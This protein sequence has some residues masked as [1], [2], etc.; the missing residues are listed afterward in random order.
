MKCKLLLCI[1][2]LFVCVTTIA[3]ASDYLLPKPQQMVSS[4]GF[5]SMGKVKLDASVL[6]SEW[7]RFVQECGGEVVD[8]S[9]KS[10]SVRMVPSVVGAKMNQ[11]E[12]YRLVVSSKGILVEATTEKGVYWALQTLRQLEEKKGRFEA[13]EIV[14]W[15]AFKIRG[16][17]HDIG[18]SYLSMDELKKE[19]EILSRYKINVF[20]WHLTE[21]QAWRLESKIFPMLNDS[22][23]MTRLH[24]KYYTIE[25][26]KELVAFCKQHNMLLIQ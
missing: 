17:M 20:H 5:F 11:E 24:G 21:N 3:K 25:E 15:P 26:A 7:N 16:F 23:N 1:A 2:L 10:I 14:D 9:S 19:I 4:G 12:A 18:R 22:V 6:S 8:K 13:C